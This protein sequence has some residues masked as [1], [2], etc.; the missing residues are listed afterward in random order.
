[1]CPY[2]F[3]YGA[4]M[5]TEI[6]CSRFGPLLPVEHFEDAVTTIFLFKIVNLIQNFGIHITTSLI[7]YT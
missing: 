2:L 3:T 6:M 5:Y 7:N 1:M 4:F